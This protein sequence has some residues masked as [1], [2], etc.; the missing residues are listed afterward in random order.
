VKHTVEAETKMPTDRLEKILSKLHKSHKTFT[1]VTKAYGESTRFFKDTQ[2][3]QER[4]NDLL[5][6]KYRDQK[7]KFER[8]GKDFKKNGSGKDF[9][10]NKDQKKDKTFEKSK[11]KKEEKMKDLI[12]CL[13]G[14][15]D[16][17]NGTSE[18]TADAAEES[19]VDSTTEP[20]SSSSE[21]E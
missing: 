4:E 18:N 9:K 12:K 2:E 3:R 13:W 5:R 17:N 6:Q 19:D 20:D 1:D 16:E 11:F 21:E 10:K 14:P 15:D 7:K 8:N